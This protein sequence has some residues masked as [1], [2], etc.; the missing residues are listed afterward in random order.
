MF[1]RLEQLRDEWI[2]RQRVTRAR[3]AAMGSL[4]LLF[5]LSLIFFGWSNPLNEI[6]LI[7]IQLRN[8]ANMLED[9]P[10]RST[11]PGAEWV[12]RVRIPIM[13]FSVGVAIW[14][15]AEFCRE[16]GGLFRPE[17]G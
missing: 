13:T 14:L 8:V 3:L 15:G 7:L 16:L 5:L 4:F 10:V 6:P 12:N 9:G 1:R 17:L 11:L 2:Q